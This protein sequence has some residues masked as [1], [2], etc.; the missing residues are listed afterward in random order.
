MHSDRAPVPLQG[1]AIS[2]DTLTALSF[3][4]SDMAGDGVVG[5]TTPNDG[6]ISEP[7]G[8]KTQELTLRED[9]L[10]ETTIVAGDKPIA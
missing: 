9:P 1:I 6:N 4:T 2:W 10:A 8:L 7:T 3:R 5:L